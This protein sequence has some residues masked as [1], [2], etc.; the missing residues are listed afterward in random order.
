[1]ILSLNFVRWAAEAGPGALGPDDGE[2]GESPLVLDSYKAMVAEA[3]RIGTPEAKIR[4]RLQLPEFMMSEP[5][6]NKFLAALGLSP[7]AQAPG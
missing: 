4:E 3:R 7:A 6:F 1:M 2:F 5:A